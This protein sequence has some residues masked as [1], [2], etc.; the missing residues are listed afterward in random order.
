MRLWHDYD[1]EVLVPDDLLGTGAPCSDVLD[2]HLLVEDGV[3]W[4]THPMLS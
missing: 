4:V 2:E 1:V 3:T